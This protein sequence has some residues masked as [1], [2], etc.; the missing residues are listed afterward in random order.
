M[1]FNIAALVAR[2]TASWV[3]PASF[4]ANTHSFEYQHRGTFEDPETGDV[5]WDPWTP[6]PAARTTS[7]S[8]TVGGLPT[9]EHQIQVRTVCLDAEGNVEMVS[10]W[11]NG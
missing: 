2:F 4:D 11:V 10:P 8:F 9:V 3:A 6:D 7:T 5:N 1:N